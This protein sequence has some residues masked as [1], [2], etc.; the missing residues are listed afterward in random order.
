MKWEL[1]EK[2]EIGGVEYS[3]NADYRNILSIVLKLD[4]QNEDHF[5]RCYIA[6]A[7][8]YPDFEKIPEASYQ[9][10]VEKMYWFISCGEADDGKPR[11]KLIDWEQD[12]PLI[13]SGINKIAACDVRG[14]EFLHWWTFISYF[15][16]I[17]DGQLATV[18]S[19]REKRRKHR[20]LDKWEQ[21]FYQKN[22]AKIDF[23]QTYTTEE[24]KTISEWTK[25]AAP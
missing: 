6:L 9:E 4:D 14:L 21:E 24:D 2:L 7:M 22:R 19:I 15:S 10:A 18:V 23:K 16:E 5:I 12:Y 13:V 3:I 20:K 17:G 25:K 8:F 11:V 1:P